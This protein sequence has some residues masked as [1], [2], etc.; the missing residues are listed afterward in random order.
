MVNVK[1]YTKD[2]C[3]ACI[4]T[5]RW[6]EKNSIPFDEINV[7]HDEEQREALI[8]KGFAQMPVVSVAGH[9]DWAGFRYEKLR[10][11]AAEMHG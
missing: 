2:D 9:G 6:L 7:E 8:D 1:V 11:L 4:A 10:G 3:S 5:K